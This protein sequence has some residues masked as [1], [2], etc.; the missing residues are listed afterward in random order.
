MP[1]H[2]PRPEAT[3][4]VHEQSRSRSLA[5]LAFGAGGTIASTVYG[6]MVVMATLTVG[7]ASETHPWKLAIL[8]GTSAVVLWISHLYAHGLAES[9]S[10]HRRLGRADVESIAGREIGILLAAAVP[11]AALL[12]GAVGVLPESTAVVLALSLGM[13]TLAVEGVRYARLEQLGLVPTVVA[14][15]A[16]LA[17]GSL[18]VL[19]KVALAH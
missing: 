5:H 4:D 11:V 14:V 2:E 6:T 17:L 13:V 15:A 18:V 7:Y 16:N 8:V 3:V 12:A 9:I 10:H 1:N 19:L